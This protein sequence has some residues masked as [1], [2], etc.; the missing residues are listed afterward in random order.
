MY[1][2]F[3]LVLDSEHGEECIGFTTMSLC[4]LFLY[5]NTLFIKK[6][7]ALIFNI[8]SGF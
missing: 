8:L 1:F 7:I 6:K 4:V 2:I 5:L 3:N